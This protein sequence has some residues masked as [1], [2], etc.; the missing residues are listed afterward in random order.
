MKCALT[1]ESHSTVQH[2]LWS[3]FRPWNLIRPSHKIFIQTPCICFNICICTKIKIWHLNS[4]E[5]CN[6]S[7]VHLMYKAG[8]YGF[9]ALFRP[10][11]CTAQSESAVNRALS[12]ASWPSRSQ[13]GSSVQPARRNDAKNLYPF[14]LNDWKKLFLSHA[15]LWKDAAQKLEL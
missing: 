9:L 10:V 5:N 12:L 3:R 4:I 8:P 1:F 14:L 15:S 2:I 13:S 6:L 7:L 11:C